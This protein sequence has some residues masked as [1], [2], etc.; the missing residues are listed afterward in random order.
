MPLDGGVTHESFLLCPYA[1]FKAPYASV[2]QFFR[3][4]DLWEGI[5][6]ATV[7]GDVTTSISLKMTQNM[8][9]SIQ[10]SS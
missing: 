3:P 10:I 8:F 2:A 5:P 1:S 4:G 9:V 6:V 7:I